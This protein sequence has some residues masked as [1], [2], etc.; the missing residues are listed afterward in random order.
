M[1]ATMVLCS[2]RVC[3]FAAIMRSR[4]FTVKRTSISIKSGEQNRRQLEAVRLVFFS[5][6]P[7]FCV[8]HTCNM[9]YVNDV[10]SIFAPSISEIN[11]ECGRRQE[12]AQCRQSMAITSGKNGP[13][14][15][16]EGQANAVVAE[17]VRSTHDPHETLAGTPRTPSKRMHAT[18]NVSCVRRTL[19]VFMRCY[20]HQIAF[21]R[22]AIR[23][24]TTTVFVPAA[25][26]MAL[27]GVLLAPIV[28]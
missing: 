17:H 5:Y 4:I 11:G 6:A 18:C 24:D 22:C 25:S 12:N 19:F 8:W 20:Q 27:R 28:C 14:T 15:S 26:A 21:T 1:S 16:E 3:W 7:F 13:P 2:A 23:H 9:L 10:L